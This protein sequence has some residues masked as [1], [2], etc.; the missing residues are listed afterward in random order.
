MPSDNGSGKGSVTYQVT[1]SLIHKDWN[2]SFNKSK[3]SLVFYKNLII[4]FVY[5]HNTRKNTYCSGVYSEKHTKCSSISDASKTEY[6]SLH[7]YMT[8]KT[9][10]FIADR[11]DYPLLG[12]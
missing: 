12:K 5:R 7:H 6:I 10:F 9:A 2:F 11:E 8:P 4:L 1:D 3:Y